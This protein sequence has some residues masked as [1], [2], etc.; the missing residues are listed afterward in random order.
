MDICCSFFYYNV[1]KSSKGE[2]YNR[3]LRK[4]IF[5]SGRC[6]NLTIHHRHA[7]ATLHHVAVHNR[8]KYS[9]LC[10]DGCKVP[11]CEFVK[12]AQLFIVKIV[13]HN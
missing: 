8:L 11:V 2:K 9:R 7:F 13:F 4:F 5:E 1:K 3:Q 6:T 10:T 12:F